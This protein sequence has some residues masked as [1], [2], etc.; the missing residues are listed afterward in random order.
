MSRATPLERPVSAAPVRKEQPPRSIQ[1][2]QA[3]KPAFTY[4]DL[5]KQRRKES[6]RP[7]STG[8]DRF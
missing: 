6:R 1:R 3:E 4:A 5:L 7:L 8:N 2:D